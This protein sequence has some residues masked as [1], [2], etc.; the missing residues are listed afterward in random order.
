MQSILSIYL[1]FLLCFW[2]LWFSLAFIN[3]RLSEGKEITTKRSKLIVAILTQSILLKTRKPD[4]QTIHS[5]SLGW[6][7]NGLSRSFTRGEDKRAN[8]LWF[9]GQNLWRS[10]LNKKKYCAKNPTKQCTKLSCFKVVQMCHWW[11]SSYGKPN[12]TCIWK[13]SQE[14]HLLTISELHVA[15][16]G[17]QL[18]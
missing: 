10:A 18:V 3:C 5:K 17:S 7:A 2:G 14:S 12:L 15:V 9:K 13:Y 4:F 6:S 11:K 1:S 8:P 16:P